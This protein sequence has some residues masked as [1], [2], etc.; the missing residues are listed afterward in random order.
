M[1]WR[2]RVQAR[3]SKHVRVITPADITGM[4]QHPS[5]LLGTAAPR[6]G[7]RMDSLSVTWPSLSSPWGDTAHVESNTHQWQ[8]GCYLAAQ[9]S[10]ISESIL[11]S[12]IVFPLYTQSLSIGEVPHSPHGK[13][14]VCT[15]RLNLT[16]FGIQGEVQQES[17][18]QQGSGICCCALGFPR[19]KMHPT[20]PE[21]HR[22]LAHVCQLLLSKAKTRPHTYPE[23]SLEVQSQALW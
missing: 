12:Q 19:G 14:H 11:A 5:L 17:V 20:E 1:G 16:L 3:A 7:R 21:S 9:T 13:A 2:K 18:S 10:C 22:R 4:G 8:C 23:T 6:A 15:S